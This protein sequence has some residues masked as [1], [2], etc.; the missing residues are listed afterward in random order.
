MGGGQ[1]VVRRA[2]MVG[3]ATLIVALVWRIMFL[4]WV[5]YTPMRY[6]IAEPF[7]HPWTGLTWTTQV[8]LW[9]AMLSRAWPWIPLVAIGLSAVAIQTWIGLE[10]AWIGISDGLVSP[11]G[12]LM[13]ALSIA[14]IGL[15]VVWILLIAR[16]KRMQP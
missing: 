1:N 13:G 7:L 14:Q 11:L 4:R 8:V 9:L 2:V 3:V 15:T 5:P 12:A 6:D 10:S 16:S